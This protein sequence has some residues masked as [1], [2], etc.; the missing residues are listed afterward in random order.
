MKK[1][2]P[3]KLEKGDEI[4][5]IAPARGLKLIGQDCREIATKRLQDMGFKVSFGSNTTDDNFDMTL[6]TSIE[7]RVAD[8]HEAFRDKNVKAVLTVIGG[9]NSN[10][11]LPFIDFDLIKNNPKIFC[12]F[13]DITSL[14]ASI[15]AKT[16]LVTFYGPHYSTM[17]MLKGCEYTIDY[18]KNMAFENREYDIIP[19]PK[20]SDDAWF[21]DQENRDFIDNEGFWLINDGKAEGT[22]IGGNLSTFCLLLGTDYRPKFEKDTILFLEECFFSYFD[23][24]EFERMLQSVIYQ[25]DFVNVKA[26]VIGRFQKKSDVSREKLEFILKNKPQLENIPIIANVD[27]G[28]TTPICT[29]PIGGYAKID[30][31]NIKVKI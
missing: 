29:L 13:S 16:G 23:L 5:I 14:V 20:W 30:G 4:R 1:I 9:T 3:N 2:I 12:G 8:I 18:W 11:L 22:I 31:K 28:H 10:Q 24:L 19:S 17:G 27:F 25:E 6:S 21:L 26:L 7:K 15:Y